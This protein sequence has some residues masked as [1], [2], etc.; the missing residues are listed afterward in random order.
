MDDQPMIEQGNAVGAKLVTVAG[1]DGRQR[2]RR[3]WDRM[4]SGWLMSRRSMVARVRNTSEG[5]R[6]GKR[7]ARG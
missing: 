3:A 4:E 7:G 1:F 5:I 2:M 6:K